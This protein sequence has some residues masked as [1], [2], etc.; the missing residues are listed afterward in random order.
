LRGGRAVARN[1]DQCQ[2]RLTV[3]VKISDGKLRG[4]KR[5]GGADKARDVAI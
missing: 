5:D 1:T 4:A 2:I 3:T